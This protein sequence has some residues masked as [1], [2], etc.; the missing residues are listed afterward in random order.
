MGFSL[1]HVKQKLLL[2]L[3]LYVKH[4]P[5]NSPLGTV[6]ETDWFQFAALEAEALRLVVLPTHADTRCL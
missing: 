1:P 3:Q 6:K 2:L 4:Q 5:T